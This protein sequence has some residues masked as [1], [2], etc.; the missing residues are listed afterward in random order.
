MPTLGLNDAPAIG[1][2][3]QRGEASVGRRKRCFR[4]QFRTERVRLY[5]RS[6]P[7]VSCMVSARLANWPWHAMPQHGADVAC[8]RQQ[9]PQEGTAA[10]ADEF[11]VR[12][13]CDQRVAKF[14]RIV[15][16]RCAKRTIAIDAA[17]KILSGISAGSE[18]DT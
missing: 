2:K 15:P 17:K 13:Q 8:R 16:D 4:P 11:G 18:I 12:C 10:C 9:R 14:V 7:A 6:Q 3:A 1:R 5:S